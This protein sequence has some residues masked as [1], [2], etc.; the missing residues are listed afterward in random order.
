MS[1]CEYAELMDHAGEFVESALIV[2]GRPKPGRAYVRFSCSQGI[3]FVEVTHLGHGTFN[4]L[5]GDEAAMATLDR[6]RGWTRTFGR[7]L[8]VERGPR[9]EFR[10]TVVLESKKRLGPGARYDACRAP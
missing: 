2:A 7:S 5:M 6:L 1:A 4:A 8:T 9:D 3:L 10:I